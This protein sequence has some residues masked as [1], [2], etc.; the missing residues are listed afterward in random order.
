MISER[1]QRRSPKTTE[2]VKTPGV[3]A[4]IGSR[5]KGAAT[6]LMFESI[7]PGSQNAQNAQNSQGSQSSLHLPAEQPDNGPF[8]RVG[9]NSASAVK[10][11]VA[12]I[13]RTASSP[14]GA[15]VTI[16]I[17]DEYIRVLTARGN[18]V[19]AW[20]E[21]E[22]PE[23]VVQ[24]GLIVDEQTF[25]EVLGNVLKEVTRSG[26]LS[27]Q[28]V[29]V[30][31]TGRNMVQRRLTVYVEDGQELGESIVA[32]ASDSMSIRSEEMQIEWD[33]EQFDLVDE[34]EEFEDD[35]VD[36]DEEFGESEDQEVD[37]DPEIAPE[38]SE[39]PEVPEITDRG[40]EQPEEIGRENL[41]LAPEPEGDP[42][43]V[44][45]LALHKHVIRR[46]L[47]TVSEFSGRFAGVQ[48]KILALA[49]AV[50]SRS[51]V[52][53]DVE[54]NTLITSV[55]TNGLPE[56][57]REVGIDRD[58]THSQSVNLIGTQISRA[59]SFYDSLVP[60]DPLG[61]DP[62][63]F[64]TGQTEQFDRAI[65]EALD[66]LQYVRSEL[67]ET[68]RAPEEFSFEKYAANVG[69][70]IVSGKRFWQ[71]APVPLLTT[72]KFDYRPSQYRP[73]PLPIRAVL[74]VA[75]AVILAFGVFT[76]FGLFTDQNESAAT[77]Q[78]TLGILEQRVELRSL[79]IVELRDARVVLNDA[80]LRTER[81]VAANEVIQDRDAGF[82][83][84]IAIIEGA[85]PTGV[86][87]T[88]LD[89]D[90]RV[91]AVQAES[92][93]YSRLLAYVRILEDVP[94]FVHVQVLN[95][96]Q[97]SG[98]GSNSGGEPA[99]VFGE[100]VEVETVIELSIQITR[101]EIA[102]SALRSEEELAAVVE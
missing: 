68:L 14:F 82:A 62:P 25:I 36:G 32:A 60:E 18:R 67:P 65:E 99:D 13:G 52:V 34:D 97:V 48:P 22:L 100:P 64:V 4:R 37:R 8:G 54:S 11:G 35:I 39:I 98:D 16:T 102:E 45:A 12:A 101:I 17:A 72:P 28:K 85:A 94:Q 43:D 24:L 79:K 42:H 21:S 46:N 70:V 63:V 95:M 53:L 50:N 66:S 75:A 78:R 29:A 96:G 71:R 55:I 57:I 31:I 88:T 84:T 40:A 47:R 77:A 6:A 80:K 3:I 1:W 2:E 44:Y 81:L 56:V 41:D 91:V 61:R 30:A 15:L 74:N 92:D 38:N 20:A 83:D 49:A 93:D 59:V 19:R 90:G 5:V 87:I 9:P 76:S 27:G 89:D 26:K 51:A 86:S 58:M 69:L 10:H 33:A 73:R 7:D 23:G